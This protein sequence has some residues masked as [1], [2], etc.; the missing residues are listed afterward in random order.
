MSMIALASLLL[1][2]GAVLVRYHA[3]VSV[4]SIDSLAYCAC[5]Y[6]TVKFDDGRITMVRYHHN[7]VKSGQQIGTLQRIGVVV[8]A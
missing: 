6:S 8:S 2:V 1:I 3:P 4:E 7:T 5:G